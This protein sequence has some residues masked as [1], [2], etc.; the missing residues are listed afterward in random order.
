MLEFERACL[1]SQMCAAGIF[2]H[3]LLPLGVDY[4]SLILIVFSRTLL[5]GQIVSLEEY[6]RS[7]LS[8]KMEQ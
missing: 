3:R 6:I 4:S 8:S 2:Q 5:L 7:K 1:S